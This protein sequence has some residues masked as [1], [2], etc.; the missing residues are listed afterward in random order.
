MCLLGLL[1]VNHG[2]AIDKPV[3]NWISTHQVHAR[4]G[5][6]EAADQDRRHLDRLGRRG[7]GCRLPRRGLAG[8]ALA[9]RRSR[10]RR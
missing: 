3:F 9:G 8:A 10:W 1:V 2:L 5:G 6:H 7:R 4:R